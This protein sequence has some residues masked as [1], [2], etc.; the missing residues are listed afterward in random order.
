MILED[1]QEIAC[2]C[3]ISKKDFLHSTRKDID[4]R[5][6][7]YQKNREERFKEISHQSWLTGVYVCEAIATCFSKN[8][9]YPQNP[10]IQNSGDLGE[11]SKKTGKSEAELIQEEQYYAMR[12]RQANANIS[13][14]SKSKGE[15]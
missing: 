3:G 5:I 10:E 11:M 2:M 4:L 9:K 12:V 14:S 13:Q 8:H 7:C 1:L 6:Q 15:D